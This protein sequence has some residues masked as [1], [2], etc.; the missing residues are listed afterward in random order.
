[1]VS[2]EECV[3]LECNSLEKYVKN[4]KETR[5]RHYKS[6]NNFMKILQAKPVERSIR[7]KA[8]ASTV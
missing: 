3:N 1:M 7:S 8:I 2:L 5:E 6:S 4:C